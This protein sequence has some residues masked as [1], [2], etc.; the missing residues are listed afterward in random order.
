MP[1]RRICES[2]RLPLVIKGSCR[3]RRLRGSE[4]RRFAER[5]PAAVR[6]NAH[7]LIPSGFATLTHL[8][9]VTKG[10]LGCSAFLKASLGHQGEALVRTVSHGAVKFV[11]L[12]RAGGASAAPT[13]RRTKK[14]SR[15]GRLFCSDLYSLLYATAILLAAWALLYASSRLEAKDLPPVISLICASRY[16]VMF[17]PWM[18]SAFACATA[19]SM[20]PFM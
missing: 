17:L 16:G 12:Y 14:T 18:C 2:P 6:Q 20:M 4:R 19:C 1:H 9:L 7:P 11:T 3:R 15:S 5:P 8:P 10:R 13:L